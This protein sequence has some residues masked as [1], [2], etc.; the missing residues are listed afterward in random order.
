M[1]Q[2]V[3]FKCIH[4]LEHH[5]TIFEQCKI[6][7]NDGFVRKVEVTMGLDEKQ[8]CDKALH[9]PQNIFHCL[10]CG[11]T[12]RYKSCLNRIKCHKSCQETY[13]EERSLCTN[14]SE[15]LT[16]ECNPPL[17]VASG[18]APE[19]MIPE[20]DPVDFL[21][22]NCKLS[23]HSRD[24][25]LSEHK[26]KGDGKK[27]ILSKALDDEKYKTC[28]VANTDGISDRE[29]D[30]H[31]LLAKAH[32]GTTRQVSD[33]FST[34]TEE[35]SSRFNQEQ[36][37]SR[38]SMAQAY[39]ESINAITMRGLEDLSNML[40]DDTGMDAG[41]KAEMLATL[42][43][44]KSLTSKNNDRLETE[45]NVK[46][47][48]L[49]NSENRNKFVIPDRKRIATKYRGN[50]K[51]STSIHSYIPRP[52]VS[53]VQHKTT[54]S[55]KKRKTVKR[56][57]SSTSNTKKRKYAAVSAEDIVNNLLAAGV[58]VRY[59]RAGYEEDWYVDKNN[60][61]YECQFLRD[62]HK[63][64]LKRMQTDPTVTNDTRIMI[65]RLWSDSFQNKQIKG[66]NTEWNSIQAFTLTLLPPNGNIS[67][68]TVPCAVTF[69]KE[70]HDDIL[71]E[72]LRQIKELEKPELKYWG[73]DERKVHNTMCFMDVISNDL[74]ERCG[75]ACFNDGGTMG[76]RWRYIMKFDDKTPSCPNCE[77]KRTVMICENKHHIRLDRCNKC[78]D[79]TS[80]AGDV[81]PPVEYPVR[82]G[83]DTSNPPTVE[84]S[85]KLL[86]NSIDTLQS[87]CQ[88]RSKEAEEDKMDKKIPAGDK[89]KNPTIGELEA[90]LQLINIPAK[91][92]N[93]LAHAIKEAVKGAASVRD[94]DCYPE[95]LKAAESLGIEMKSFQTMPMHLLFLGITKALIPLSNRLLNRNSEHENEIWKEFLQYLKDGQ[96]IINSIQADWCMA[97]PF[98]EKKNTLETCNW[99]SEHYV[100][101][102][103]FALFH[104]GFLDEML[105]AK[106][107]GADVKD[108]IKAF[109]RMILVWVSLIS[110]LFHNEYESTC[111]IDQKIDHY[112]KLFLSSCRHFDYV[113]MK[114]VNKR[115]SG[116][117]EA[118]ASR[119][120]KDKMRKKTKKNSEQDE[121][122]EPFYLGK[123]N[124]LSLL[125]LAQ[126]VAE[127]GSLRGL[128]EGRCEAFIKYIKREMAQVYRN[129]E[130][131]ETV[132]NKVLDER[133]FKE[134]D[135][136]NQFN[137]KIYERR[138]NYKVYKG[139]C[140]N[141]KTLFDENDVVSGII[142]EDGNPYVCI[143]VGHTI[144][145]HPV[146]FDADNGQ[147]RFN[148]WYS[149][150]RLSEDKKEMTRHDLNG[151]TGKCDSFVIL[152][153]T[154]K[155]GLKLGTL[156]CHS[157]KVLNS[158]GDLAL[159]KPEKDILMMA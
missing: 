51:G 23:H 88:A 98:S 5:N 82:P 2:V 57:S 55:T 81:P 65:V 16:P 31:F 86:S 30:L 150:P 3:K 4:C 100:A 7:E 113:S 132:L 128:W 36:S 107:L 133:F 95:I 134:V 131:L 137:G 38:K 141:K 122:K 123:R 148:L 93:A 74:P 103:R 27:I 40:N 6:L 130:W 106:D 136:D 159:V 114:L 34:I 21:Q 64:V 63:E 26:K 119:K 99:L 61:T 33:Y 29:A 45:A 24:F 32:N 116:S 144:H 126:V 91:L 102:A 12:G 79:W 120:G 18:S 8:A 155:D 66:V 42:D 13:K 80:G 56:K 87:W 127:S 35:I 117:R 110:Y 48:S 135:K 54:S 89:R 115:A 72:I 138:Y 59:F 157:Y 125:N 37:D 129:D 15:N 73:G 121:T 76:K 146:E 124:F 53:L 19:S 69:K 17:K 22:N 62:I 92:R 152:Q 156:F 143:D 112:V 58:Q 52:T 28:R 78:E 151:R 154:F 83:E 47:V 84:S 43:S 77:S 140:I 145:L 109:R 153:R 50:R 101:F 158:H 105:E 90:Y 96:N 97:M 94:S 9:Q 118:V 14:V 1:T 20:I 111:E 41:K 147:T 139:G 75:N 85:F 44:L 25:Y 46:M 68:H 10:R 11:C 67:N 142:D 149:K 70:D 71:I 39:R 60:K 108:T 104:F 49:R